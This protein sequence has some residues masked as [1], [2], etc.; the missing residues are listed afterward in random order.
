MTRPLIRLTILLISLL[1]FAGCDRGDHPHALGRPAPDF[2]VSD[3]TRTVHLADYR[4][5]IV[6]LNFWA[7]WC[8]PCI[9]ELPSLQALQQDMPQVVVIAVSVDQDPDAYHRF[10]TQ[11]PLN[12][13]TVEDTERHV[14]ALYG[15][16][17]FP[18]SYLID[19]KGV[20]QR[21]FVNA[22]DWTNPEILNYI[23]HL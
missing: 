10:L 23:S 14:N 15:T 21:K 17:L 8:A 3:G 5:K 11:H 6:L 16:S 4:G 12:L 18:E 2:T 19:R 20:I 13:L 9:A 1:P 7:T 22:Q